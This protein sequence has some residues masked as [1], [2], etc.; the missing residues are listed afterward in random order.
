MDSSA[1]PVCRHRGEETSPAVYRCHSPK[2]VGLKLVTAVICRDCYCR[3][4][5][6]A[7]QPLSRLA[8]LPCA[9]LGADTGARVPC[10][11]T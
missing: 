3:D 1:L 6:P 11:P 8:L 7:A 5:E 2:L 10:P 9:Y 4:H